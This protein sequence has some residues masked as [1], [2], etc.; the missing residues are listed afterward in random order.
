MEPIADNQ[1]LEFLLSPALKSGGFKGVFYKN[2]F[3]F[4]NI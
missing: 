4:F 2:K 3:A 1:H